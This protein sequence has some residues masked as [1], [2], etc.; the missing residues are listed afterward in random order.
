MWKSSTDP[1]SR[2]IG[3]ACLLAGGASL[4]AA[5]VTE[6]APADTRARIEKLEQA[7]D[8]KGLLQMLNQ[9]QALETEL[10]RLR[11]EVEVQSHAMEDLRK[12]QR[13]LYNDLDARLQRLETA[14]APVSDDSSGDGEAPLETLTPIETDEAPAAPAQQPDSSLSVELVGPQPPPAAP[15]E[16]PETEGIQPEAP[17]PGAD[18]VRARAAYQDAFKLLKQSLYEQAIK[19]FQQFLAVYPD[20]EYSDNAQYWLGEAF[21]VT[22]DFKSAI[23]E[24]HKVVTLYPES[25]KL[26]EALLKMAYSHEELGE[27]DEARRQLEDLKQRYPGTTAARL[28]DERLRK[29]NSS[30]RAESPAQ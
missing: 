21:F 19:S 13:D 20:S 9:V 17:A 23:D 8:N 15:A 28:A 30:P 3:A 18:P 29:I 7:L 5:P 12:R 6:P 25:Q 1:V 16:V 24:Y 10:Q 22:R 11:G 2:L 14:G 26:T 4:A 27:I